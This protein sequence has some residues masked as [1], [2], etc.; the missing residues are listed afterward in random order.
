M[1]RTGLLSWAIVSCLLA[2][3]PLHASAAEPGE[4][5]VTGEA[6]SLLVPDIA[7]LDLTVMREAD[8]ARAAL[9]E[10]SAAM[11]AVLEA[12]GKA[13][14]EARDL[15]TS[16]FNIQPRY[17]YDKPRG[18]TPPRIV[19][20]TVRNSLAVTVRDLEKLGAVIDRAVS[21]GVNEGG[22]IRFTNA[23]PSVALEVARQ[24]AV[25]D[26]MAKAATLAEAAGVRLGRILSLSEDQNRMQP[27]M[28]M[29][30]RAAMS[31]ASVPIASGE[32]TYRVRVQLRI[33]I[34]Q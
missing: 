26:A 33:A 24:L 2:V 12:M 34:E 8:T 11:R 10:N 13:G 14:V 6:Q 7:V 29:E 1:N 3:L 25:R 22:N 20:Y 16:N 9:D 15:Q 32:N 4:I 27:V 17:H 30:A 18:E 28:M 21:L 5:A 23:D 31:D 19:G